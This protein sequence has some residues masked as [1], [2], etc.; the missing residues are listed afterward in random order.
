MQNMFLFIIFSETDQEE[1]EEL[2]D[3]A[4]S[5]NYGYGYGTKVR[6]ETESVRIT[7]WRQSNVFPPS[8]TQ[9]NFTS[10]LNVDKHGSLN[11]SP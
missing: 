10:S 4:E 9:I 5:Q 2:L 11:Q 8:Q 1:P 7:Y 6:R 3:G